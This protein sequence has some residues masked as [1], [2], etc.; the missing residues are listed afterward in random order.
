MRSGRLLAEAKPN[1]LIRD[2]N[3]TVSSTIVCAC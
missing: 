1:D 3:V 2:F